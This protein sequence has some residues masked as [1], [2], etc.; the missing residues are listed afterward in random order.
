[1]TREENGESLHLYEMTLRMPINEW[2]IWIHWIEYTIL[3]QQKQQKHI[4]QHIL[5]VF[6]SSFPFA[7]WEFPCSLSLGWL[8]CACAWLWVLNSHIEENKQQIASASVAQRS[9]WH[10]SILPNASQF[11]EYLPTFDFNVIINL[12]FRWSMAEYGNKKKKKKTQL[13][14]MVNRF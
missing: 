13:T 12:L 14:Q 6:L 9:R 11:G 7:E 4:N 1:M 3:L 2:I 5:Y 8:R 10:R